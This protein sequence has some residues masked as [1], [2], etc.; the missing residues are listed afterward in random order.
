MSGEQERTEELT[1]A[2][3]GDDTI[4]TPAAGR[5]E[6]RPTEATHAPEPSM[7]RSGPAAGPD[8]TTTSP[9]RRGPSVPTVVWG[10]VFAFVAASVL[11]VELSDVDLNLDVSGPVA[12]LVVGVVLVLWGIAGLGRGRVRR[13]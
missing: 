2:M 12:L 11:A 3:T 8:V 1:T 5:E 9:W 10:L 7:S 4:Q 6:G 13:S